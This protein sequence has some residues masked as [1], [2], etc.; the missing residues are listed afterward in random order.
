M[1]DDTSAL[2]AILQREEDSPRFIL[3]VTGAAAVRISAGTALEAHIVALH[4]GVSRE[5]QELLDEIGV[6]I[7]PF[8]ARQAELAA[9]GYRRFGKGRHR[10]G[11]NFGDCF[12]YALAKAADEPLLFK[13]DD[14]AH[15]DVSI[16]R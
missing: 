10:A 15:T 16:A 13:G 1:I 7:V 4:L 11:L 2:M 8:D 3:A 5:L 6:E 14:F 12:A 9:D